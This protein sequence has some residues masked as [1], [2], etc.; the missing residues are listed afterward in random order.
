MLVTISK[1]HIETG[2][3][4]G[5]RTCP[6]ALAIRDLV[7]PGMRVI[8]D[9]YNVYINDHLRLNP[10]NLPARVVK[11]IQHYDEG[12]EF[13]LRRIHLAIPTVFFRSQPK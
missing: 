5:H 6:L 9:H 8:V 1:R 11:A 7:L 2:Q 10:I 4:C 13:K 3:R 12:G